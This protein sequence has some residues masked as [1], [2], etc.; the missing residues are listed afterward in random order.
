MIKHQNTRRGFTQTGN[1][2]SANKGNIPELVSGSSTHVV[3]QEKQQTTCKSGVSPTIQIVGLTPNLQL[4]ARGFTLIELL[5]VV[6]IIG[7][8]AAIALPQYQKAVRKAR[9]AEAKVLLKSLVDA[10]DMF[11]L[12]NPGYDGMPDTENLNIDVPSDTKNWRIG[13][14]EC[15]AGENRKIGCSIEA[16]PKWER[17]YHIQYDSINYSGGP[18]ENTFAG[19]FICFEEDT[20]ICSRLS[21]NLIEDGGDYRVYEL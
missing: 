2:Q 8:L 20:N 11:Y 3:A 19:K 15:A 1:V 12:E 14:N 7:I 4:R 16:A 18:E 21:S 5:V 13:F 17:G 6:L 10:T 9:I